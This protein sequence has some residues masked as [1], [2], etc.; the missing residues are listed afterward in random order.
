MKQIN[1]RIQLPSLLKELG[2]PMTA[3]EVGCAEGYF[4]AD[5]LANGIET[6]YM[7]DNWGTLSQAGDA[8]NNQAWHDKNYNAAMERI[9]PYG[10]KAIILR[11]LSVEMAKKIHD[12]SLGLVYIDCDHSYE[13]V[14]A[15]I[16]AFFPKLVKGA[17]M[18]FH[19]FENQSYGVKQAVQEFCNGRFEIH[20]LP[21][22]KTEDA[23]A[24]FI[25]L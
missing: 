1:Y 3:V 18:A 23:G 6:L 15:D 10:T 14:K 4:S 12:N 7:V 22:N 19:D 2:L 8:A 11:G 5:L 20:L 24:F 16:N 13:G 17:V 21:E 9:R 25:N